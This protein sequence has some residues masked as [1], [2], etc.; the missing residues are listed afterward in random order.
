M[1]EWIDNLLTS[2]GWSNLLI[3]MAG[4]TSLYVYHELLS[5]WCLVMECFVTCVA[6]EL[7]RRAGWF[8]W[9]AVP[10]LADS[11]GGI[12]VCTWIPN[13][14]IFV[15]F[16]H[17][18]I[19]ISVSFAVP[20][21]C[22]LFRMCVAYAEAGLFWCSVY[23][24]YAL[25]LSACL[26]ALHMLYCMYCILFHTHRLGLWYLISVLVVGIWCYWLWRLR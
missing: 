7:V 15:L 3:I 16:L 24:L 4:F 23:V 18:C 14:S 25:L 8:H 22:H 13:G 20:Y 9:L 26:T 6:G 10:W 17:G 12:Y 21:S 5:G 19:S 1:N 11:V 2:L